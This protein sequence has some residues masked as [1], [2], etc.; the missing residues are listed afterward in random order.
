MKNLQILII[1][2]LS[3]IL[4]NCSKNE[5]GDNKKEEKPSSAAIDQQQKEND[6]MNSMVGKKLAT[7][8]EV[9]NATTIEI[10]GDE[11]FVLDEVV[12]Y[13]YS[14]K[15]FKLLRKFGRE[16]DGP[17]EFVYYPITPVMMVVINDE[18]VLCRFNKIAFFSRSGKLIK[19]PRHGFFFSQLIPISE[20]YAAV[21]VKFAGPDEDQAKVLLKL[22][23][24]SFKEIKTIYERPYPKGGEESL[25]KVGY[26]IF[27]PTLIYL[28]TSKDRLFAFDPFLGFPIKVYDKNGNLLKDI[29]LDSKKIK[30]TESFKEEIM[31]WMKMHPQLKDIAIEMKIAFPEYIPA[32]RSFLVKEDKIYAYTYHRKDNLSEFILFDTSKN[33]IVKKLYLPTAERNVVQLSINR[34]YTIKDNRYYY[35]FD[36][37][38]EETWELHMVEIK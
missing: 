20:N 2:L 34:I 24:H 6:K 4:I 11:L 13:V 18:V 14:M 29:F 28:D 31:D 22:F 27:R 19:Q 37:Y 15:D 9:V 17:G 5:K 26:R 3:V 21:V 30:M 1:L 25:Q 16:G 8:R 7:L 36:N 38:E 32:L 35:L 23:D 12:V 33:E 10:D